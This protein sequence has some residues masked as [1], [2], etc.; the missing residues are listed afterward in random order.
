[1]LCWDYEALLSYRP[2]PIDNSSITLSAELQ[3][4]IEL[5]A[6]NNH[7][8]W[9]KR[10]MEEG[11][12]YGPARDDVKKQTPVLVPYGELPESEKEYDRDNAVQTIKT[13]IALG[14]R[15]EAPEN[16]T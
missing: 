3:G 6:R 9:A 16:T 7:E 10:R 14:G 5:L 4:L 2:D 15:V 11:W 12:I 1:L 8:L 13:I